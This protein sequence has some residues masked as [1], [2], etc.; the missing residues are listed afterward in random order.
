M[1]SGDKELEKVLRTDSEAG[2]KR[3]GRSKSAETSEPPTATITDP[4]LAYNNLSPDKVKGL[5]KLAK[6]R[7]WKK[8]TEDVL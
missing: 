6:D 4:L 7:R 2:S 5:M 8:P 3:L 1:A